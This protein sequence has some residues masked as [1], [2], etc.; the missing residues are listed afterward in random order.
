M[1][2]RPMF[3]DEYLPEWL[4]AG[5]ITFAGRK[6]AKAAAEST[7]P[8]WER[9]LPKLAA[10]LSDFEAPAE[11]L[12]PAWTSAESAPEGPAFEQPAEIVPPA[13]QSHQTECPEADI[14][15]DVAPH[16]A[17]EAQ[18][19]ES[20][21]AESAPLDDPFKDL[22]WTSQALASMPTDQFDEMPNFEI[23]WLSEA[24][25]PQSESE[26]P[27]APSAPRFETSWLSEATLPQ[28]ESERPS[29]PSAPQFETDWLSQLDAVA[30]EP[31]S[32]EATAS[33]DW[34]DDFG[35]TEDLFS[36]AA[37]EP[38]AE[39]MPTLSEPSALSQPMDI[40]APTVKPVSDSDDWL[41]AL[42]VEEFVSAMPSDERIAFD[43]L[44]GAPEQA[45]ESVPDWLMEQPQR[46]RSDDLPD[47][48]SDDSPEHVAE[49]DVPDWLHAD[50]IMPRPEAPTPTP[51]PLADAEIPAWM[52][53]LAPQPPAKPNLMGNAAVSDDMAWLDQFDFESPAVPELPDIP[54]PSRSVSPPVEGKSALEEI[55]LDALLGDAPD[56]DLPE[57][58]LVPIDLD[59]DFD[60]DA[61]P[62]VPS[63][64]PA[65]VEPLPAS[66][67][68]VAPVPSTRAT[69]EVT[70]ASE[71]P[72]WVAEMRPDSKPSLRIGDQ[73]V[74]LEERPLSALPESLLALRERIKK[75][76]SAPAA[77][78]TDSPLSG[79]PEAL[80]PIA[81]EAMPSLVMPRSALAT[82][83][84]L[85]GVQALRKIVAAQEAILKHRETADISAPAHLKL[86]ARLKLDRLVLTIFLIAVMILPFFANLA[87]LVPAPRLADLDSAAQARLVA[88]SN[89]VESIPSGTAVLVAF[90]YAPT[91]VGEM[92]D[93]A[94][95]VLRD[96][97]R[98][99]VR[100][101]VLSTGPASALHAQHLI[102]QLGRDTTE[103]K[104][105]G[106]NEPFV[107]RR[108]YNVLGYLPGGASGVRA[109]A[110]ALYDDALQQQ[111]IFGSDLNGAPSGISLDQIAILRAN[112]IFVLAHN[113]ET[114]QTWIEQFRPPPN[115]PS[116][117]TLRLVIATSA[118][119]TAA[120]QAY[121]AAE[122]E[123]VIG[124][125]SGLRDAL[126]YRELRA[127]Y[128]D[129]QARERAERRWQSV[130]FAAF[131]AAL[132]ILIGAALS[133]VQYLAQ[134]RRAQ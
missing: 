109:L 95:A 55:D 133:M 125:L 106:R 122:P 101:I 24:T 108:D 50:T 35:T 112:P 92:D 65:A 111:V 23:S 34:L 100:P 33:S 17:S 42:G 26:Q 85:A 115:A 130:G 69:A 37:P 123:R 124:T 88:V 12:P 36:S 120:V 68:A 83:A 98:R 121:A 40:P 51:E 99:N 21:A 132:A 22:E 82:A 71:L 1:A 84:Q 128:A 60:F 38:T 28:S 127:Q 29:A 75:L 90:E 78:S 30:A 97:F 62:E 7:V 66:S 57:A 67:P 13:F 48:L 43:Q 117:S 58:S 73:E 119:A 59:E 45:T 56:F 105:L 49:D 110:N 126:L 27:S 89:A 113:Q 72:E 31:P 86:R 70:A 14:F 8:P 118:V 46:A 32:A 54:K 9:P 76:P 3:D 96:L 103:L 39:S 129:A 63:A 19:A 79:I 87:D 44:Q 41:S 47:W 104:L 81:L 53:E 94:R 93:L 77:E 2:E 102:Y 107:P 11:A 4:I 20:P 74:E 64:P 91:A 15:A 80:Q 10:M 114:V 18:P 52:R 116:G 25:L 61:L 6:G 5:G 16:Q 134:R 131:A